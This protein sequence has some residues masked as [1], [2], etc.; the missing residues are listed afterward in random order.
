[1]ILFT[2][3]CGRV[4]VNIRNRE[5]PPKNQKLIFMAGHIIIFP[6][7]TTSGN[8]NTLKLLELVS[9]A[10]D[11]DY[12]VWLGEIFFFNLWQLSGSGF[13]YLKFWYIMWCIK[14]SIQ[15]TIQMKEIQWRIQDFPGNANPKGRDTNL[16]FSHFFPENCMKMKEIRL[17]LLT[18]RRNPQQ[19]KF[20]L[21]S[22]G[23]SGNTNTDQSKLNMVI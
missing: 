21:I 6:L 16:L 5:T 3:P 23:F 19:A 12:S 8:K 2:L 20:F 4:V 13:R 22:L 1:M 14:N 11:I 9:M 15:N 18:L 17:D 10:K 7:V